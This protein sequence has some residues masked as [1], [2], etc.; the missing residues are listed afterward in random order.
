M[1]KNVKVSED[2]IKYLRWLYVISLITFAIYILKYNFIYHLYEY[3][4]V[5]LPTFLIIF[6]CGPLYYFTKNNK[7][8]SIIIFVLSTF[9]VSFFIYTAGGMN[10][11]GI[12]WVCIY[13]FVGGLLFGLIGSIYG[14]VTMIISYFIFILLDYYKLIPYHQAI[15]AEF[16]NEKVTNIYTFSIVMIITTFYF[17]K[18]E[19]NTQESLKEHQKEIEVLFKL[20]MHDVATP[21]TA[22]Q[23]AV[24]FINNK[25]IET[26]ITKKYF[27]TIER[28]S[29]IIINILS[30][31]RSMTA[32]SDGKIQFKGEATNL[33]ELLISSVEFV[34]I[35]AES[36]KINFI[37]K[38]DPKEPTIFIDQSLFKLA[39]LSNLLTNAIKFSS[40]NS[41]IIISSLL[42]NNNVIIEIKD[43]GIGIPKE[44][45]TKLFD[46]KGKTTRAGTQGEL[47][48]G[49]GMPIMKSFVEK[50][51]GRV[52]IESVVATEENKSSGSTFRLI[53]PI[54]VARKAFKSLA[55]V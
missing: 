8:A 37:L 26:E 44:I 40:A 11:P 48:T 35:R 49:Y 29:Q 41:E 5:I 30:Q 46:V 31:A 22:I 3:N 38:L 17:L 21:V 1:F 10:A 27:G 51:N 15:Q 25:G 52:E 18:N 45:L 9:L 32:L 53:F 23:G 39:I 24:N 36:K 12:F 7:L 54:Y 34:K 20:L 14:G 47:G 50:F 43:H 6:L 4:L 33:N 28:C 55:K 2:N 42:D 19:W 16:E 13:P